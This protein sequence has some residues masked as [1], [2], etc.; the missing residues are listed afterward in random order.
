[1]KVCIIDNYDSFTYN[2]VHLLQKID[3]NVVVLKNICTIKDIIKQNPDKIIISP[4]PGNPKESGICF[5]TIDYFKN[6]LPILGICLGHQIIAEYFG[7]KVSNAKKIMH[8]KKCLIKHNFEPIF[9]G[10]KEEFL[11]ARYHSLAIDKNTMNDSLKITAWS[12][13]DNEIMGIMHSQ[14]PIYGVQFHPESFLSEYGDLLLK[15]F[16]F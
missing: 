13:E 5:E 8:G 10:L 2:I 14:L 9:N 7:A 12:V 11:V 15:N 1:M 6:K 3:C 4:G 16:L